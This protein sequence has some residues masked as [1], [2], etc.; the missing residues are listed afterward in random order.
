MKPSIARMVHYR[1]R[2]SADGQHPPECVPAI[3][4][5]L[6]D[7]DD[8]PV[9]LAV[10]NKAGLFFNPDCRHDEGQAPG[11]WHWP[12][13]K[14]SLVAAVPAPRPAGDAV[15]DG[16]PGKRCCGRAGCPCN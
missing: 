3:V 12:E 1:S 9:S 6:L 8:E 11:T 16:V 14:P 15:P 13:Q 2:G 7:G 5:G 10:I 4:T